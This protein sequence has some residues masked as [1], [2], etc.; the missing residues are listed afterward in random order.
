MT[1]EEQERQRQEAEELRR[2]I[3]RT[4][5]KI[6]QLKAQNVKLEAELQEALL[7]VE[8]TIQECNVMDKEVYRKMSH[9]SKTVGMADVS[10][11]EVFQA[12]SELKVQYFS[13]KNISTAT[14]NITQYNDEYYTKFSN[15]HELR[16][17]SLGYVIGIDSHIISSENARKTVEKAYL[18][19]TEYWL[20]YCISS[21]MLWASDE[22]EAAERAMAKSLSIHYFNSCLFYLLINLRFNRID[23][24][25]KW[26]INFL[27]RTD[28]NNLGE[29]WQYL[30]QAYLSGAF[31][32]DEEFQEVISKKFQDMLLQVEVTSVDFKNKFTAKATE[33]AKMYLHKTDHD[34]T[35][36]RRNCPEYEQMKELLS[37]A[38]KNIEI[39]KYYN[40]I[41]EEKATKVQELPQKIENIL[42]SLIQDYDEEELQV[43]QKIKYN[44]AIILAK[45]DVATAQA[46]YD[47]MFADRD[48]KKNFGDLVL[49][50]AFAPD[51]SQIDV[52]VK[53]FSISFMKE[54]IKK[55][56]EQFVSE[57]RTQEKKKYT[58]DIDGCILKCSEKD[59]VK[60]EK[61]LD[62]YYDKNRVKNTLKDKY[63]QFYLAL[64]VISTA[65]I[66]ALTWYFSPVLLTS[67][68]L[69]GLCG[70][71]L[72]WRRIVDMKQILKERKRKG[73]ATL[74]QAL[75][76]LA[77][78]RSAYK[79]ADAQSVN[80]LDA[81]EQF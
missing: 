73:K 59:Y 45:G 8:R 81:I 26:Y 9:L 15:Y 43:V 65:M 77:Q 70:S 19:N 53:R 58:F 1:K 63:I 23:A 79:D 56:L 3:Q 36:L 55:G 11:K 42:Y 57:Y 71:F 47:A 17:I 28:V 13:F 49:N 38:E 21:V 16:R 31:G 54:A 12:L 10:T 24:A 66:V 67:G 29:E 34:Y 52:S 40:R 4:S 33:F 48:K 41:L 69:L 60:S 27:D 35:L 25:R 50:W 75:E 68:I 30:L 78:W 32:G 37:T 39:A 76:E 51:T 20:A 61:V 44:E 22:K 2:A 80:M 6:G 46:S 18:Q 72:L 74:K 64:C 14:K 7:Y 62:Q 5:T